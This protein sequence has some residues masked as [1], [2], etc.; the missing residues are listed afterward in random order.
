ML[1]V[2]PAHQPAVLKLALASV[3]VG[4]PGDVPV[5]HHLLARATRALTLRET[6]GERVWR[7]PD[8]KFLRAVLVVPVDPDA[9]PGGSGR[10][11]TRTGSE[12]RAT[13]PHQFI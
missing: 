10:R 1:P 12:V 13:K 2:V 5:A 7:E 8:E 11:A 3:A 9:L 6:R 4:V